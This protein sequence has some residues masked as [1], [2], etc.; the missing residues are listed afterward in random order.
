MK[1]EFRKK[2]QKMRADLILA[3]TLLMILCG[4]ARAQPHCEATVE[5]RVEVGG[6]GF[7]L[8]NLLSPNACPSLRLA[9]AG[10]RLGASPLAG[11]ARVLEGD[12]V[13]AQFAELKK[14]LG[15][16]AQGWP[17][18]NIPERVVIQRAGKRASCAE[19]TAKLLASLHPETGASGEAGSGFHAADFSELFQPLPGRDSPHAIDCGAGD[20][21]PSDVPVEA[22]R[23]SWNSVIR[24]LEISARCIHSSDCVP[25]L[26]RI[27]ASQEASTRDRMPDNATA[28]DA[29]NQAILGSRG[30]AM[31]SLAAIPV[32]HRG[33][34]VTLIWDADGIRVVAAAVSLDSGAPGQIVRVR[35]AQSGQIIRAVVVGAGM[36]R[37]AA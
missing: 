20:R 13:R 28:S 6:E 14:Q 1:K 3:S 33:D 8:A 5:A 18:L 30:G 21:I 31:D 27:S 34:K 22:I 17:V 35:L 9:A 26:I 4:S 19:I 32:V 16:A 12:Q 29:L 23:S 37:A 36:L 2:D 10:V 24:V 15:S 7:A 25:F 11:S